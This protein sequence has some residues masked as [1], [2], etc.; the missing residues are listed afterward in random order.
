MILSAFLPQ[1]E[2]AAKKY[3]SFF[4][5]IL[6]T[7]MKTEDVEVPHGGGLPDKQPVQEPT[8]VWKT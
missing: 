7:L 3:P 4:G 6:L 1:Q 5:D 8:A 2:A